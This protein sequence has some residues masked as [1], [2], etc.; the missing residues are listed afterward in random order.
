MDKQPPQQDFPTADDSALQ[1]SDAFFARG[2]A[3][4]EESPA[5]AR[6]DLPQHI[7]EMISRGERVLAWLDEQTEP[8][9][10]TAAD[11]TKKRDRD[12]LSAAVTTMGDGTRILLYGGYPL[13]YEGQLRRL[14]DGVSAVPEWV[15][16]A[17]RE[18][19]PQ[20]I[21]P[22]AV[23]GPQEQ[24]PEQEPQPT[25]PVSRRPSLVPQ[26]TFAEVKAVA[27]ASADRPRGRSGWRA[28]SGV[29]AQAVAAMKDEMFMRSPAA[30][31][32]AVRGIVQKIWEAFEE[33]A[34]S[35]P[36]V[37]VQARRLDGRGSPAQSAALSRILEQR[38]GDDTSAT[39]PEEWLLNHLIGQSYKGC[40]NLYGFYFAY[41]IL[42]APQPGKPVSKK[43]MHALGARYG[44]GHTASYH[45]RRYA[46]DFLVAVL[47]RGVVD[48]SLARE[49]ERC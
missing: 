36:L 49:P 31:R 8:S 21:E 28:G 45:A 43:E 1:P 22:S 20:I 41:T 13:V 24:E 35:A 4:L 10:V 34:H 2:R 32:A 17:L 23:P 29:D 14:K 37:L 25:S 44:L 3:P 47:F 42:R 7:L 5:L 39:V 40:E 46:E 9:R 19:P 27:M 6:S 12:A 38:M 48:N 33:R 26:S 30:Q 11:V 16:W 18:R 15:S